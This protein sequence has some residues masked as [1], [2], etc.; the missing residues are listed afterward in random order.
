MKKFSKQ[1]VMFSR[2]FWTIKRVFRKILENT[3]VFWNG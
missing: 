2:L 1:R 3:F